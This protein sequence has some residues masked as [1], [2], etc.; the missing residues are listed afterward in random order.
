VSFNVDDTG[1]FKQTAWIGATDAFLVLDRDLNGYIDQGSE[2]FNNALVQLGNRGLGSF[3]WLDAN[4]DGVIN[5]YDPVYGQLLVWR[6]V[7]GD[8]E[9]GVSNNESEAKTLAALGISSI[10][11]GLGTYT[12][13]GVNYG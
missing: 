11:Y 7:N 13:N 8:G 4:G 9:L 1:Y 12:R 10:N 5:A 3:A 6:D 2:L